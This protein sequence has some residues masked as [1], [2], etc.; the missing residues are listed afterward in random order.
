MAKCNLL[1]MD[2]GILLE[3][4]RKMSEQIF[5]SVENNNNYG[6]DSLNGTHSMAVACFFFHSHHLNE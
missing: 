4:R 3:S 6:I 5:I 1:Q 2:D